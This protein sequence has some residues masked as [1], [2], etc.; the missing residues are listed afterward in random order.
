MLSFIL[1]NSL[2]HLWSKKSPCPPSGYFGY[3][4]ELTIQFN[5]VYNSFCACLRLANRR[6]L[7]FIKIFLENSPL[8]VGSFENAVLRVTKGEIKQS[9]AFAVAKGGEHL[10]RTISYPV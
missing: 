2:N 7:C 1:A 4:Y 10:E 6:I 9:P 8:C 3:E 5:T